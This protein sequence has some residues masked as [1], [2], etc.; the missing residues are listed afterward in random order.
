MGGDCI[1]IGKA[2]VLCPGIEHALK[3]TYIA[4]GNCTSQSLVKLYSHHYTQVVVSP[5]D[6]QKSPGM[7]FSL[8]SIFI[9]F[10]EVP[11]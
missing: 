4:V 8:S 3:R 10:L 1:Y 11:D 5:G 7:H 6:L 2:T 9:S